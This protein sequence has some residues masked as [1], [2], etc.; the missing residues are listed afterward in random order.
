[1]DK[2]GIVVLGNGFDLFHGH[3]TKCKQFFEKNLEYDQENI[4]INYFYWCSEIDNWTDVENKIFDILN[5]YSQFKS[6]NPHYNISTPIST[7]YNDLFEFLGFKIRPPFVAGEFRFDKIG[8]NSNRYKFTNNLQYL[9]YGLINDKLIDDFF[10]LRRLLQEYI[11]QEVY[12]TSA[13]DKNYSFYDTIN[14]YENLIVLNF[15]YAYAFKFYHQSAKNI[16]IHGHV[17][18]EITFGHNNI[19]WPLFSNFNKQ[20]QAQL[21]GINYKLEFEHVLAQLN[22]EENSLFDLIVLGHSFSKNDHA[23]ITWVYSTLFDNKCISS[24]LKYFYHFQK[25]NSDLTSR[26]FNIQEFFKESLGDFTNQTLNSVNNIRENNASQIIN[27]QDRT[28]TGLDELDYFQRTGNF[29]E[30]KLELKK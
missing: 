25:Q 12:I 5:N 23:V 19:K 6:E 24:N 28:Y 8:I 27:Q 2:L 7:N 21:A 3:Q 18:Q 29:E 22:L 26:I 16:F 17:D 10:M 15:N 1:M 13:Y 9:N 20:T 30:I 4:W 14:E 11:K